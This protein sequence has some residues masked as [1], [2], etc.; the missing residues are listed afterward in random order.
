MSDSQ[1]LTTCPNCG[2][3]RSGAYCHVCGQSDRDYRRS[4][5]PMLGQLLAEAFEVDGRIARSLRLLLFQPGALSAEFSANRRASYV[6]PIRLYLATS[7]LFFAVMSLSADNIEFDSTAPN[8]VGADFQFD[9]TELTEAQIAQFRDRVGAKVDLQLNQVLAKQD[10]WELQILSGY[11]ADLDYAAPV[12]AVRLYLE[13]QMVRVLANPTR[14]FN[15]FLDKLPIATFFLLPAYAL[16]LMIFYWRSRK[17]Y[18][19]HLVYALHL[20]AFNFLLFTVLIL[21]PSEEE[22]PWSWL[23]SALNLTFLIYY[24]KSLRRYYQQGRAKTLVKYSL[25]LTAYSSLLVPAILLVMA[26]TFATY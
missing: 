7:I 6:S 1:A 14:V 20:H 8:A 11:I 21:V 22:G 5:P 24:Y 2:S 23:R 16:L 19:E 25:L 4:L 9:E 3:L 26:T 12:P 17:Y 18:V 13:T 10:R 15:E